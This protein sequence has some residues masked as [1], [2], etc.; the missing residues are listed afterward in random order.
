[1]TEL[2]LLTDENFRAKVRLAQEVVN[3]TPD[4]L[5]GLLRLKMMQSM[6]RDQWI[7][8]QAALAEDRAMIYKMSPG[9]RSENLTSAIELAGMEYDA[10]AEAD[11]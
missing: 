9:D 6:T 8:F 3:S 1:M 5:Q 2:D 7:V 4:H 11:R 10:T